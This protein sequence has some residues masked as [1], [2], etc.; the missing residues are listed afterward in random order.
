MNI[1][2]CGAAET[3]TGSCHFVEVD[4]LRVLLDCGFFQGGKQ[5][6]DLNRD[7]FP[8]D[9]KSID[10]V[11][12]SH[13]HLDHCGRLPLLVN[14]GFS[15]K[16]YC[17]PPTAEIAKLMLVDSAGLQMNEAAYRA[18]KAQR[19]GE[20]VKP[21]LYDM[22]D[23]I[24]CSDLFRPVVGYNQP[25][26]LNEKVSAV[27]HDAGHI[28]GSAAIELQTSNGTLLF[29][30][31]LGN[32]H[33]PIVKDPCIPPKV[34]ILMIESTYGDRAHRSME[35]TLAE[36]KLAID[37]IIPNGGN[38]MIPSF[39]LE[40]SQEVLY[41]LFQ[42]WRSKQ[43]PRCR[44]FLDSPLAISTTRVFA[45][46]EDYFDAEGRAIFAGTP[47][48]FDFTPLRFTQT[49]DESKEINKSSRGNIIIAG[50]GMCT[51]GRIIHHLRHNLWHR[52][53]GLL[54]V[55]Y[56]AVGTLGRSIVDGAKRVRIHGEEIK[57]AA[58]VWTTNGFSSHADQPILLNWI[59]QAAP[60]KLILVHGEDD[61][62]EAFAAKI[63][64]DL[65]LE[66]QIAQLGKTMF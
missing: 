50:S 41:A 57:V 1:T 10:C 43:L 35:D 8:F 13:A 25:L 14:R 55:G 11:L 63:R 9:P 4:G 21:P 31:D 46:Y 42:L 61:T 39:A 12:L 20:E 48:P 2:F 33:Q 66:S 28:L 7:P 54:F 19:R 29:S 38:L 32:R 52:E 58:K 34:D 3:V 27:F 26:R 44:I 40:R 51:G 47:N 59:K 22:T 56:Q 18:R 37:T 62:L 45:R 17:T 23:V 53:S 30:G 49:T 24:Q 60:E 64:A 5:R 16:I 36:F 65:S 6:H 15:G